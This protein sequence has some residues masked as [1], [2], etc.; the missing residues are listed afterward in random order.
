MVVPL[1]HPLQ[2]INV[3]FETLLHGM[4]VFS[5]SNSL[6]TDLLLLSFVFVEEGCMFIFAFAVEPCQVLDL[7]V[8]RLNFHLLSLNFDL[9]LSIY[10]VPEYDGLILLARLEITTIE[11]KRFILVGVSGDAFKNIIDVF[12]SKG[13]TTLVLIEGIF[14]GI[15]IYFLT[16]KPHRQL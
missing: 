15:F 3:A 12:L 7:M 16:I 9:L 13:R 1:H 2:V 14:M 5:H 10:L 4:I 11:L 8:E 6:L